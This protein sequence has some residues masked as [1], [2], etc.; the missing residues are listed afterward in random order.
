MPPKHQQGAPQSQYNNYG[1]SVKQELAPEEDRLK[2]EAAARKADVRL[3]VARMEEADL[4]VEQRR[5]ALQ[6]TRQSKQQ[7][8]LNPSSCSLL[9]EQECTMWRKTYQQSRPPFRASNTIDPDA[10]DIFRCQSNI[11]GRSLGFAS[12]VGGYCCC[13]SCFAPNSGASSRLHMPA[14]NTLRDSP[15]LWHAFC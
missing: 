1:T 2:Q 9:Q 4:A 14:S 10:C 3:M 15:V 6:V 12:A 11:H 13:R 5:L 7:V 8:I